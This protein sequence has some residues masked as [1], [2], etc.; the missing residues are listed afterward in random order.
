MRTVPFDDFLDCLFMG[1]KVRIPAPYNNEELKQLI[2]MPFQEEFEDIL[3]HRVE[4]II[5]N[6][7]GEAYANILRVTA[8][9]NG[10]EG[11]SM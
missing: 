10:I 5:D 7:I 6:D 8:K 3:L 1:L 4:R 11:E 2:C 9:K